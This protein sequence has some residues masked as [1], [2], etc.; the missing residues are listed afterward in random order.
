MN[1][2]AAWEVEHQVGSAAAFHQR[3]LPDP[4]RRAV[5]WFDVD[6][7]ALVLGSAQADDV[8]DRAAATAAGVDVVRRRSGGGAVLLTPGDV[9]WVDVVIPSDDRLWDHDVGRAFHWLGEAWAATLAAVGI[10]AAVHR[11]ALRR[12]PW[13]DLV[14]FAGLG[15]G[16]V[17][18]AGR[19]AVG[20]SQRR[21]R[22][23]AR[24]QC[25]LLHRW[26][27][28]RLVALLALSGSERAA[29]G[30]DLAGTAGEIH[31]AGADL[32]AAF[33]ASLPF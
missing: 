26:E 17:T 15:P 20:M 23:G 28:H 19:K 6:R 10:S 3:T 30:A 25:A 29:A 32:E 14:C 8:A 16:E 22:D 24:F 12:G 4:V 18:V 11:G 31:C 7:P 1:E 21:S 27:P 33:M 9:T 2:P 5:W 13:S